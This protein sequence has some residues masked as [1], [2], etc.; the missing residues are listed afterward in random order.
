M[1]YLLHRNDGHMT[2]FVKKRSEETDH[3]FHS[4]MAMRD[5]VS[6]LRGGG[7]SLSSMMKGEEVVMATFCSKNA[8]R[9]FLFFADLCRKH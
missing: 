6:S 7:S 8:E 1:L 3:V 4:I 5:D 2:L 9:Y